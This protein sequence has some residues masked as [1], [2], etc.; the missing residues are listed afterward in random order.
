MRQEGQRRGV[1]ELHVLGPCRIYWKP[2][3]MAAFTDAEMSQRFYVAEPEDPNVYVLV[4]RVDGKRA[5]STHVKL[6]E[7]LPTDKR[8]KV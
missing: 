6:S 2:N 3:V 7:V 4:E 5:Y 8:V 1:L